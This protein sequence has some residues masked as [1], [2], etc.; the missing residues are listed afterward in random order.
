M[1]KVGFWTPVVWG[2]SCNFAQSCDLLL[3]LGS[4]VAII[5]PCECHTA[6][7]KGVKLV[8]TPIPLG[9]RAIRIVFFAAS[10]LLS[11]DKIVS[12]KPLSHIRHLPAAALTFLFLAKVYHR[13]GTEYEVCD[14]NPRYETP[15]F[16]TSA[17]YEAIQGENVNTHV[18]H[19]AVDKMTN[20]GLTQPKKYD[21]IQPK[22]TNIGW[23]GALQDHYRIDMSK[24][25]HAINAVAAAYAV[26]QLTI[27]EM[28]K[29]KKPDDAYWD[30]IKDSLCV[31]CETCLDQ[32]DI[33]YQMS[34]STY[35]LRQ[36]YNNLIDALEPLKRPQGWDW[37][38]DN[39]AVQKS[40]SS[41]S[42]SAP[43]TI[44]SL[45][46]FAKSNKLIRFQE[47]DQVDPGNGG[48]QLK[49][50]MHNRR[51]PLDVL[52]GYSTLA[53]TQTNNF[54]AIRVYNEGSNDAEIVVYKPG[55]QNY[56]QWYYA[57]GPDLTLEQ[58]KCLL[59]E[60]AVKVKNDQWSLIK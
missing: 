54:L 51:R 59:E 16:D 22:D 24:E 41:S 40:S 47:T 25:G 39:A 53:N 30:I 36:L 15:P 6:S 17:L 60:G 1:N 56:D 55:V 38:R 31:Y 44:D 11:L 45:I 48:Y 10:V 12:S 9:W 2:N 28:S 23:L 27:I 21:G 52:L 42:S 20:S 29:L 46:A 50:H 32:R 8:G 43:V 37:S 18:I 14:T 5:Q 4:R 33:T 57:A 26:I 19:F 49:G 34:N 35:T 58:I 7:V 3:S 13:W